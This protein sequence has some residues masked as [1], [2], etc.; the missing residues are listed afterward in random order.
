[1][2][3]RRG[4]CAP[5]TMTILPIDQHSIGQQKRRPSGAFF[6]IGRSERIRTSDPLLPKQV[7]YQAALRSDRGV[8][9][10]DSVGDLQGPWGPIQLGIS[11]LRYL[12][13]S[14]QN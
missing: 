10:T 4:F 12:E 1:M 11:A 9:V 6:V 8:R 13:N 3:M 2:V 5:I 14:H 7:R